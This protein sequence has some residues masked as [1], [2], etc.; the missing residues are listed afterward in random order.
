M[1]NIAE[2]IKWCIGFT[3]EKAVKFYPLSAATLKDLHDELTD[4]F[5]ELNDDGILLDYVRGKLNAKK[6]ELCG[7]MRAGKNRMVLDAI[8]DIN[9]ILG[10]L[11]DF[12]G[13]QA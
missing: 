2:E 6:A 11:A 4:D 8:L 3:Y 7:M 10:Y 12:K 13:E 1:T 5:L 9:L